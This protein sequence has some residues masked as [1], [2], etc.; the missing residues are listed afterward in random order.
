MASE[1][2]VKADTLWD[3]TAQKI[4]VAMQRN[5]VLEAA[6]T[7]WPEGRDVGQPAWPGLFVVGK[8]IVPETLTVSRS[9]AELQIVI[10]I[11]ESSFDAPGAVLL[12]EDLAMA[13]ADLFQGAT[14]WPQEVDSLA[15]PSIDMRANPFGAENPTQPWSIVQLNWRFK[16]I[17][18]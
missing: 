2:R 8:T 10:A 7:F 4:Q 14:D 16:Y 12:V 11:G 18:Q 13:L 17:H 6:K 5:G 1:L 15:I 9:E 3:Y